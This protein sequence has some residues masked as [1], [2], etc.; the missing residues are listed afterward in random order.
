MSQVARGADP[1]K[2]YDL[3]VPAGT[4]V[5]LIPDTTSTGGYVPLDP[6]GLEAEI[7]VEGN[8]IRFLADA[9]GTSPAADSGRFV[10]KGYGFELHS[11]TGI[12]RCKV[13]SAAGATLRVHLF[14]Y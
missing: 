11:A 13:Y 14:K 4:V 8:D 6:V 1:Y 3:S 5:S 2:Y 10:A 12:L 9:T 7:G